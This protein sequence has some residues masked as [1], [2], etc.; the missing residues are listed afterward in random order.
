[1]SWLNQK[2]IKNSVS[3]TGVGLHSGKLVNIN[4][5]PSDPDTG[6]VFKR[7]DLKNDNLVYPN[8]MNVSNTALNTTIINNSGIK[9]ST[10][11]HVMVALFGLVLDNALV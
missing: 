11:E 4:I 8:F 2:T 3:F 9:V 5:K 1:M 6:I 7:I 10:I